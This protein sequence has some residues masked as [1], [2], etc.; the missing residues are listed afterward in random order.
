MPRMAR[1][2][3]AQCET[4]VAGLD[5]SVARSKLEESVQPHPV[6]THPPL[7]QR[8]ENLH[9]RLADFTLPDLALLLSPACDIVD[10]ADSLDE[11]LSSAHR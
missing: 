5:W 11:E 4:F 10:A 9:L 1:A 7:L 2:Y 3:A 6:D 8:L